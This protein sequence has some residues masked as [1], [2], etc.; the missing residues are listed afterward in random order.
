MLTPAEIIKIYKPHDIYI[1]YIIFRY[2]VAVPSFIIVGHV[3]Q[4]L[5][6]GRG[7][8]QHETWASPILNRDDILFNQL[9]DI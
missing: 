6:R 3:E 7:F 5:G 9:N 2:G 8:S 4:I 1:F